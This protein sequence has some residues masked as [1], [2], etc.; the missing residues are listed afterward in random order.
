MR[1]SSN[2]RVKPSSRCVLNKDFVQEKNVVIHVQTK[3]YQVEQMYKKIF[4]NPNSEK[5]THRIRN[6]W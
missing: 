4:G 5:F 6:H 2:L 1:S 3:I